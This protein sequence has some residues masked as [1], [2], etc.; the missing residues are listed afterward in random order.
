[1]AVEGREG[2]NKDQKLNT[3]HGELAVSLGQMWRRQSIH[4]DPG[5]QRT[6]GTSTEQRLLPPKL[7]GHVT[8]GA[9]Q[10]QLLLPHQ[11][12]AAQSPSETVTQPAWEEREADSSIPEQRT[13][14]HSRMAGSSHSDGTPCPDSRKLAQHAA[15]TRRHGFWQH[16]HIF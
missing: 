3:E 8:Q 2:Q 15:S 13:V 4:T 1:M 11:A 10:S 16:H 6:R 14:A 5:Q 12:L 9:Q 7:R